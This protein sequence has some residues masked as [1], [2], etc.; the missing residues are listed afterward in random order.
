MRGA[1]RR[2]FPHQKE[3][4]RLANLYDYLLWRG[5]LSF[6]Q[7][8]LNEVDGLILSWLSYA[9]WDGIVPGDGGDCSLADAAA[10]FLRLRPRPAQSQAFSVNAAAAAA[11]LVGRLCDCPRYRPLRLSAFVNEIDPQE[12]KQFAALTIV[13]PE[14]SYLSFRG[15]D[16]TFT[17]W[18]ED[19]NLSLS[20][21]VPAQLAAVAYLNRQAARLS[22][23]PLYVGGHSK[24][25]NLAVYAAVKCDAAVQ[26]RI[27]RV[28]NNDGPGFLPAF[29]SG[30]DY[31]RVMDRIVTIVPQSSVVGLLLEHRER[32]IVV[33]SGNVGVLQ[34]NSANWAVLGTA[35]VRAELTAGSQAVDR[36]LKEW[37]ATLDDDARRKFIDTLFTL[38]EATGAT[39][40]EELTAE[41]LGGL[42]RALRRLSA[43]DAQQKDMLWRAVLTLVRAG[44]GALYHTLITPGSA[45]LAQ[46]QKWL[47]SLRARLMHGAP[48]RE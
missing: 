6:S 25:G 47:R 46:G 13:C 15:T 35:F 44:N 3:E 14:F 11:V 32:H 17:G 45:L 36:T 40:I 37:M 22:D 19:C 2:V 31:R 43:M 38:L 42:V 34:H 12:Q 16:S 26:A 27:E 7:A 28:Y 4:T 39:R 18:R 10:A 9:E 21:A 23:A 24:G 1:A 29:L 33:K 30:D 5:D 48:R 41:G 20:Q 8:P